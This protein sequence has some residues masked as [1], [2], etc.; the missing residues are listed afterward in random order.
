MTVEW[1][2]PMSFSAEEIWS[3]LST[4]YPQKRW[5]SDDAYTVMLQ[6]VLVQH[7]SW[8]SVEK[9]CLGKVLSAENISRLSDAELESFIRPCGLAKSKARTIR[10][11]TEWFMSYGC[12]TNLIRRK[13]S[14]LLRCELMSI[15]GIGRETADVILLYA[16]FKPV[17]VVDAYTRRFLKRLGLD[18][19]CDDEI[20]RMFEEAFSENVTVYGWLHWMI[21]DFSI[22][23]CRKNPVCRNCVFRNCIH[24]SESVLE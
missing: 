24:K 16:F 11:L 4:L 12:D 19:S 15:R 7:T 5:W 18:F 21:L 13:D 14:S 6:A 9:V 3:S 10:K 8:K 23:I 1:E 2:R 17:M 22:S 20:R